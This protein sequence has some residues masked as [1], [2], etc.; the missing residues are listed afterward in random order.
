M[1]YS[2]NF[3]SQSVQ[4]SPAGYCFLYQYIGFTKNY[5]V[6]TA[7]NT[8]AL[9]LDNGTVVRQNYT[10]P[11]TPAQP[12][13]PSSTQ[14]KTPSSNQ[15]AKTYNN[16]NLFASYFP[17]FS[18]TAAPSNLISKQP[19]HN[20]QYSWITKPASTNSN[21]NNNNEYHRSGKHQH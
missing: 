17:G 21:N 1:L 7:N 15:P 14:P 8:L 18:W 3:V 19:Q 2:W 6:T 12:K 9:T 5:C 20:D 16:N 11:N 4:V 13:T 10:Q